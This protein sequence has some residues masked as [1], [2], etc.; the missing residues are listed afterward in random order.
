ML[1]AIATEVAFAAPLTQALLAATLDPA[2]V[3]A[4]AASSASAAAAAAALDP[5][6]GSQ[7]SGSESEAWGQCVA[8][9]KLLIVQFLATLANFA[10]PLWRYRAAA[11]EEVQAALGQADKEL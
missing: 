7:F 9:Y 11:R 8:L 10:L 1:T 4:S 3:A 6:S 2:V 5:A